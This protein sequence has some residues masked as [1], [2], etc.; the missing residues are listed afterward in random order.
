MAAE[1]VAIRKHL[2]IIAR[3]K[4][5]H[6]QPRHYIEHGFSDTTVLLGFNHDQTVAIAKSQDATTQLRAQWSVVCHPK[7]T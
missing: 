3:Q 1:N 2:F 5:R 7:P 6:H 4:F